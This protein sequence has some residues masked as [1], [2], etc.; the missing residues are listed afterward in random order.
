VGAEG[1][2]HPRAPRLGPRALSISVVDSFGGY[3]CLPPS[4]EEADIAFA[5]H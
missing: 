4:A 3:F 1:D 2:P 5:K